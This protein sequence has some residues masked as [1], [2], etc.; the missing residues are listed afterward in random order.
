MPK[1]FT[2]MT[3]TYNHAGLLRLALQKMLELDGLDRYVEEILVVDNASTDGTREVVAEFSGQNPLVRYLSEPRQGVTFARRHAAELTTPWL[4]FV[5]D[6]NLLSKNYLLRAAALIGENPDVGVI[7]GAGIAAPLPGEK[8]T[9]DEQLCL[10]A[11]A[12]YLACSHPGVDSFKAGMKSVATVP[13]GAGVILRVEPLKRFSERGW[14][15]NVGRSGGALT[16]GEDGE[17]IS[18]VLG[19]GYRYL[20]DSE[21][22]F[23][24]LMPKSR[25]RE[26]YLSRLYRGIGHGMY[27][28]HRQGPH[29]RVRNAS[30]FVGYCLKLLALPLVTAVVSDPIRKL[31]Y[32]YRAYSWKAYNQCCLGKKREDEVV[33]RL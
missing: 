31:S 3:C 25:L 24:H 7:N 23:Y 6:D 33:S 15:K 26:D 10:F 27:H 5:D 19:E 14:T 13:Y 29:G 32:H 20:Y 16:S 2:L 8:F 12:A 21:M 1:M 18:A 9:S 22:Y 17:I 11:V 30:Y 4:I 28:Y